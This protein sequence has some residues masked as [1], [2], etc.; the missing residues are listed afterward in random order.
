MQQH[1]FLFADLAGFTALTEAHG[2]DEAADVADAFIE[3]V[4]RLLAA[5][6]AREVKT[7]GDAVMVHVSD[8]HRAVCL[9]EC[10][11]GELGAR[12]GALGVRVG[13]HTGPAVR[14]HGDWFGATVNIASRV[15]DLA[16]AD[17]VLLT[18]A[19]L[20]AAHPP[21]A[22]R[23]IRTLGPHTLRNVR[24]PVVLHALRL[25]TQRNADLEVD[26]VCRMAVRPREAAAMTE[27]EGALFYF[28]AEGCAQIFTRQPELYAS[29]QALDRYRR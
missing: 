16:D 22:A 7:M 4:R 23:L 20:L 19:T 12:H 25:D 10:A 8:A 1:T 15:A 28:C 3:G 2:D 24:E 21:P 18:D 5:H 6:E 26:P 27:H 29:R 17:E 9:A 11:V 13:M 14:R